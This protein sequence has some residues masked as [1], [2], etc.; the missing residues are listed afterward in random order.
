MKKIPIISITYRTVLC[1]FSIAKYAYLCSTFLTY[2]P[3][4]CANYRIKIGHPNRV[5]LKI[6]VPETTEDSKTSQSCQRVSLI[7]GWG[8]LDLGRVIFHRPG[9]ATERARSMKS[10]CKF[11]QSPDSNGT[12]DMPNLAKSY[13]MGRDN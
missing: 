10:G 8:F 6:I 5:K 2:D 7:Q 11:L 4:C 3:G 1:W 12:Q 13:W 9:P